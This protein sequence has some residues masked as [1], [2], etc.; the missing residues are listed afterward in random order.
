VKYSPPGP[1][2]TNYWGREGFFKQ[3]GGQYAGILHP[4]AWS[5][6]QRSGQTV[7]WIAGHW[8]FSNSLWVDIRPGMYDCGNLI[9]TPR[10][11]Q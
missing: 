11:L 4:W 2:R 6:A 10:K 1:L 9:S 3:T 5:F 8:G 7:E